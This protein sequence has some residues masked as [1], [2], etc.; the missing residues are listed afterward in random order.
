MN[1]YCKL[2]PLSNVYI[3]FTPQNLSFKCMIVILILNYLAQI[4]GFIGAWKKHYYFSISYIV[5]L[6]IADLQLI[7]LLSIN[8]PPLVGTLVGFQI[9]YFAV[10]IFFC[11]DLS[12]LR[13]NNKKSP[14]YV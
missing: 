5:L 11:R 13:N 10:C 4:C 7:S 1:S 6:L 9:P 14:T 3:F 12:K 2:Y 8:D